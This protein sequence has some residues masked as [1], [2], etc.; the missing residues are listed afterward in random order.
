MPN[1]QVAPFPMPATSDKTSSEGQSKTPLLTSPFPNG[2]TDQHVEDLNVR[3]DAERQPKATIGK[4]QADKLAKDKNYQVSP[5]MRERVQSLKAPQQCESSQLHPAPEPD[6]FVGRDANVPNY[7]RIDSNY[8]V[9]L[10][11]DPV[12]L[13]EEQEPK[14]GQPMMVSMDE[15][16][17]GDLPEEVRQ[18]MVGEVPMYSLKSLQSKFYAGRDDDLEDRPYLYIF[19]FANP[20]SGDQ[21]GA[22]LTDLKVQNFRLKDA[23]EVEV[24]IYNILDEAE[25]EKGFSALKVV[26][27]MLEK[28]RPPFSKSDVIGDAARQ[29]QIHVWSAGGDGTVMTV[30]D[31]LVMHKVDLEKIFFSCIP[32]GTGNDFSQVLG[33]GRTIKHKDILGD[34]MEEFN[35]VAKSRL[36]G[37]PAR[38]DIWELEVH[39]YDTGYIRKAGKSHKDET[40]QKELKRKMCNYISIGVQGWVGSGFENQRTGT[41]AFNAMVYVHESLKWMLF[42]GFPP[43]T[44]VIERIVINNETAL[45]CPP[46]PTPMTRR[47]KKKLAKDKKANEQEKG[48]GPDEQNVPTF[49]K[50]PIDFVIQNVPHIWGREVDMWGDAKSGEEAVSNRQ[51]PT[52]PAN[53]QPQAAND[54]RL[55]VF[56]IG[57]I[58]SY[59]KKLANYRDHV[60][61]IGQFESP[62]ELRFREANR[63]N[64]SG[65]FGGKFK[66]RYRKDDKLDSGDEGTICFM[67]DGEFYEVRDPKSLTLRRYA[68]ITSIGQSPD[69]SRL[70]RDEMMKR[71]AETQSSG[72]GTP[73]PRH[74]PVQR[75]VGA[76]PQ[77]EHGPLNS[78]TSAQITRE[79]PLTASPTTDTPADEPAQVQPD[80]VEP[81]S[82]TEINPQGSNV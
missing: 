6:T 38:L 57:N 18:N 55:E 70:V 73:N 33:W 72:P 76:E 24:Q 66:R 74:A 16:R 25:R 47:Y 67:C 26:E 29:R 8:A 61:R 28:H 21:K 30:F 15:N 81:S 20:L 5:Q 17:A 42:K 4:T 62:F 71:E 39:C 59:L 75:D 36:N 41:R 50:H 53:W 82:A 31:E 14:E 37:Y 3:S 80:T 54:G 78:E 40:D 51:G 45:Y 65:V 63:D 1:T 79:Q 27:K 35:E 64:G 48:Q 34:R 12:P 11:Q 2:S 58:A 44:R 77:L 49:Q 56:C 60:S 10:S 46:P 13:D 32:F 9:P 52:D 68:Q 22:D 69:S 7:R 23:P 19:I 43:V